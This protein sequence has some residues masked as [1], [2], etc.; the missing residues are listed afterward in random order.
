[1]KSH[2]F[3]DPVCMPG[4]SESP[5]AIY[6]RAQP[7]AET[8]GQIYV[9][10]RGIPLDVATA[11]GLRF[12]PN[13]NGRPAVVAV[14]KNQLDVVASIHGRYLQTIRG[15]NKMLT[16]GPGD[17]LVNVLGGWHTEPL[18]I[19]EGLFDALSLAASGWPAIAPIGRNVSWLPEAVRGRTVWIAFDS[20]QPAEADFQ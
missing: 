9:E 11:A 20:C 5:G 2:H 10:R 15:Q 13:F 8:P 14:L 6:E 17:G 1:M 16:I 7:L 19:V 3:N 12:A 4:T 18:I